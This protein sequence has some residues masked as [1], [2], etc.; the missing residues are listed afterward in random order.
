MNN[1]VLTEPVPSHSDLERL[2]LFAG[3]HLGEQEFD[4]LQAYMDRRVAPLLTALNPGIINGLNVRVSPVGTDEGFTLGPGLAI[5]GN[6]QT[7]GLYYPL[8]QTW[9]SLIQAYI[10]ETQALNAAGVF[11]LTLRRTEAYIDADPSIDPCQRAEFDPTRDAQRVLVGTIGLTRLAFDPAV[12]ATSNREQVENWVAANNVDG[13]FIGAM[14][15]AVPLGVLAVENTGTDTEGLPT[16]GVA[17]FSEAA[18]RYSA[19]SD[20]GYHVLLQ[21][22]NHAFRRQLL[23]ADD[24]PASVSIQDYLR[25]NLT[26]DF[27][28][29][30]GELPRELITDIASTSPGIHWLPQHLAIDMVAVPEEAVGELIERHLP[31]RVV[32][33]RQP[34]GDRLRLLLALNERDYAP[35][36]LDF[37][38]TDARLEQDSYRYFQRAYKLWLE[39]I[40]QFQRLYF[41]V[42][43]DVLEP[44]DLVGLD[45]PEP[46]E[47]PQLPQDFYTQIIDESLTELGVQAGT[48]PFFPYTNGRPAFPQFYRAWGVVSGSGST[49]NILPPPPVEP[50]TD[51][52]VIQYAIAQNDLEAIDNQVRAVRSRLEKTRDYLLLQ[53]QQLDNQTVSLAALAGGVAGDG[54]GLQVARWLPFTQLKAQKLEADPPVDPPV[55]PPPTDPPPT[56]SGTGT[57]AANTLLYANIVPN[58][59]SYV[60]NTAATQAASQ[61][62]LSSA[63]R[64]NN[65]MAGLGSNFGAVA[66]SAK[67]SNNLIYASTLRKSPTVYSALQFN[68]N[69]NRLDKIAEAPKQALT[70]PAFEA[71]EF[72]FGVLEHVRPEI[73]EYKKALRGM[74]ELITTLT[75]LFDKADANSLRSTLD[76]I[77]VPKPIDELEL[78]P[79]AATEEEVDLASA[80]IYEALFQASQILTKQIA[81]VEGRYNRIEAQLEGRLRARINKEAQIEKLSALIARATQTLENIDKRRIEFLGDYGVTQRLVDADWLDVFH[82]N[83]ERTRVLTSAVQGVY[84]VRE[85]QTSLTMP[86]ADP[87]SLR[88]GTSSDI[89]PGC[90][91]ETDPELPEELEDFFDAILE[92]PMQDWAPLK[93]L[94]PMIPPPV[95]LDY[96]QQ[97][98][99][100]RFKNKT[101]KRRNVSFLASTSPRPIKA[102]LYNVRLQSQSLLSQLATYQFPQAVLSAK[103]RRRE[104]AKV[105]SLEDLQAGAKGLLQRQA[106][107]LS[108]RLEQAIYCLLEK[109]NELPPS[110]RLQW[111]QLAE[112]DR[113][114]VDHVE[115]WPGLERAEKDDF[116]ATRTIAEL[117]AWCWRQLQTDASSAGRGAL[118][119]MLRAT[120]IQS[121]LGDPAEILQGQVQVPPRRLALGEPLRLKLNRAAR[122]GTVLQLMNPRQEVVALLNVDDDDD[123]GTVAQITRVTKSSVQ[124]STRYTVVAS[125]LTQ[126]YKF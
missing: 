114:Q 121:A 48:T 107:Q 109:L 81:F 34:A 32:D 47:S 30:A 93:D 52:Y 71:K 25:D 92:V 3:R 88:H 1:I 100:A 117:V 126:S 80:R 67:F 66:E 13:Q 8:R 97:L 98:R 20:S 110:L 59:M 19:I 70:R 72:R 89:V 39:W 18:G 79:S 27:L 43:D 17:W 76:G 42:D 125:R 46:I 38:Q 105:M 44:A 31:R 49:E 33:L 85:R 95:R 91:W 7:L 78:T 75:D 123:K 12:V 2:H 113:L 60:S 23:A 82:R 118:R 73:Q 103:Q 45:L 69:N 62:S 57:T 94:K 53:R 24:R 86:L 54:S 56:D 35:D 119:N 64:T 50:Q 116:N 99:L 58:Y 74:R 40:G 120:I 96:I 55:D 51:G 14:T 84:F 112:D 68:L 63:S 28:P 37:P 61:Q 106:Q 87:L 41:V 11:Y 4:R 124:I 9:N 115:R 29:A 65:L 102:S 104:V 21:Q 6:G 77:G 15:N 36:L 122:P 26:L 83:Q 101:S 5:A 10:E 16:Y 108:L 111:A 90:D 22:V